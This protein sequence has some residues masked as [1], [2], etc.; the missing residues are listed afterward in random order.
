MA[1]EPGHGEARE[2]DTLGGL[3]TET[4]ERFPERGDV[5]DLPARDEDHRDD[6]GLP[7]PVIARLTVTRLDGHRV[8]RVRV[9]VVTP[10][11]DDAPATEDE[12]ATR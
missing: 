6:D 8:D 7:T 10:A 3:L 1:V 9:E 5:V 4:L 12:E 2:S 11:E